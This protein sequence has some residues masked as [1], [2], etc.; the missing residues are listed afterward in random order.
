[1]YFSVLAVIKRKGGKPAILAYAAN[2]AAGGDVCKVAEAYRNLVAGT[3]KAAAARAEYSH[4]I[5]ILDNQ[6]RNQHEFPCPVKAAA[7]ASKA[8]EKRLRDQIESAKARAIRHAQAFAEGSDELRKAIDAA[9]AEGLECD[10][11]AISEQFENIFNPSAGEEPNEP[12]ISEASQ[13]QPSSQPGSQS[14]TQA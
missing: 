1:M 8:K 4:C 9:K 13:S 5:L 11:K 12:I 7:A 14:E 3:P 2:A 10:E 6:V